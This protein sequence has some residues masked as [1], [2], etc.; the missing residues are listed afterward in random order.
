MKIKPHFFLLILSMVLSTVL[1]AQ[2]SS[3][4]WPVLKTYA[5]RM[6]VKLPCFV[7]NKICIRHTKNDKPLKT[8]LK[9]THII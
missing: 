4:A 1:T 9:T 3:Q 8:W 5:D 7:G 2:N 6:I